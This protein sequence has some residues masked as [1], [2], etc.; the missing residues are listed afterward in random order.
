MPQCGRCEGLLAWEPAEQSPHVRWNLGA[1]RCLNCGEWF[2]W[3]A[4]RNRRQ[5][6]LRG[7][8]SYDAVGT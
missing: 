5:Q 4:I 2:D 8:A 6:L 7:D 1:W 3:L